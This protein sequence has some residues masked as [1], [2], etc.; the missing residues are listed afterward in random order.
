MIIPLKN[1]S[2]RLT[3]REVEVINLMAEGF[4]SK[5]IAL[6][7]GL[8]IRTVEAHRYSLMKK[9]GVSNSIMLVKLY[10][11]VKKSA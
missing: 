11:E 8:S 1:L 10:L 2:V 6:E 9:T 5:E 3:P 4:T 7:L